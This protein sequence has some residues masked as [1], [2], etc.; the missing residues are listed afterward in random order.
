MQVSLTLKARSVILTVLLLAVQIGFILALSQVLR[1]SQ[2]SIEKQWRS[3]N[4]IRLVL[5]LNRSYSSLIAYS[6]T[7][8]EFR[9][10]LGVD[11]YVELSRAKNSIRLLGELVN[12][13]PQKQVPVRRIV[14]TGKQMVGMLNHGLD[15]QAQAKGLPL[16]FAM[17]V[18]FRALINKLGEDFF[19]S[20]EEL[21]ALERKSRAG[22]DAI[23]AAFS[24]LTATLVVAVLASIGM[25]VLLGLAYA[26]SIRR[27]LQHL[28]ENAQL[29]SAQK[30][31]LPQ[32]SQV[33]EFGRLDTILHTTAREIEKTLEQERD[34]IANA[35]DLICALDEDGNFL[36][37]NSFAQRMLG[38]EPETFIGMNVHDL[39]VAE[40]S[41]LADEHVRSA[42]N[43]SAVSQ[44]E[45]R[46]KAWP[47]KTSGGEV[48]ITLWSCLWS[49]AERKLFCVVRDITEDKRIE[50]LKQDF[51]DMISH[52]LRSPLMAMGNSLTLL[53]AGAKGDLPEDARR[54]IETSSRN[55]E[56]L[57]V[58]VNDLLDFQKLK[59]GKMEL[60]LQSVSLQSI[61]SDAA[62]LVEEAALDK[63]VSVTLPDGETIIRCD[64]NKLMQAAVN[65]IS[66]AIKFSGE[67]G[68]VTV[69]VEGGKGGLKGGADKV[70]FSV[71]DTGPGVAPEFQQRIFEPFEQAPSGKK[72][73][74]TGLGLA[75]CKLVVEA[76]GGT[77]RVDN[78]ADTQKRE[79]GEDERQSGSI[80][81]VELPIDPEKSRT[82]EREAV[83]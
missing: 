70:L 63:K 78:L 26:L 34:T 29:L 49:D 44:F 12:D 77:I 75:I 17:P 64:R 1:I 83:A 59:A 66:N 56:K 10:Y 47:N 37:V 23:Q 73:E 24:T 76:H 71:M 16:T 35:A 53:K 19:S 79:Q 22:D 46:L 69:K 42:V 48:I 57:I 40:E 31:L 41:L 6:H 51:A 33:D 25:A 30:P 8:V 65:L 36:N 43:A 9:D 27:P 55:V 14:A 21:M 68:L 11:P 58:L 4:I 18:S 2:E 5:T 50:Q 7:P 32:L 61:I 52:D 82:G 3:E 60:V 80:F 74:G 28:S 81:T 15:N 38:M 39:A 13:D 45:L 62:S 67:G 20:I 54:R 72:S